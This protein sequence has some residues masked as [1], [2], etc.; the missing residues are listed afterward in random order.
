MPTKSKT[1]DCSKPPI[2][3]RLFRRAGKPLAALCLSFSIALF[4]AAQFAPR[5]EAQSLPSEKQTILF[6]GVERT[7]QVYVPST[8][9]R[10]K[11]SPLVF[12]AVAAVPRPSSPIR[13]MA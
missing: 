5:A 12:L 4:T 9:D 1:E 11:P 8:V 7:F 2:A 3:S 13:W 10:T 6:Q